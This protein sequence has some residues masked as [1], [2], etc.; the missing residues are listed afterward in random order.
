MKL[1]GSLA[2]QGNS[3][4]YCKIRIDLGTPEN[5]AFT[6]REIIE[7]TDRALKSLNTGAFE[8]KIILST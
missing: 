8:M 4:E 1:K 7:W 2:H 6:G 3:A 5:D